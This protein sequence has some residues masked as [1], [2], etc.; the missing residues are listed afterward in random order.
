MCLTP[1]RLRTSSIYRSL[2]GYSKYYVEVPCCQCAECQQQKKNDWY[3]R[4]YF[5]SQS[6][7]K[8][9]DGYIMLISLTY[10][11]DHLPTVSKTLLGTDI[12]HFSDWASELECVVNFMDSNKIDMDIRKVLGIFRKCNFSCF[13][14]HDVQNFLKLLRIRL[15]RAGYKVEGNL[16]YFIAAEYGHD[17]NY[18]DSRGRTRKGTNR[19]HYHLLPY[20]SGDLFR[21]GLTPELLS[22]YIST[23]WIYG[24]TDGI[25]YMDSSYVINHST[26]GPRYINDPKRLRGVQY[27]VTKYVCKDY[28]F[29]DS[30]RKRVSY[31]LTQ[32]YRIDYDSP[33]YKERM[34]ELLRFMSQF[35]RQSL[36]FGYEGLINDI[37]VMDSIIKEGNI[38]LPDSDKVVKTF[39]IPQYYVRKIF[40]KCVKDT[41]GRLHWVWNDQGKDW[42]KDCISRSVDTLATKMQKW[43][44]NIEIYTD[45]LFDYRSKVDKILNGRSFKDYAEYIIYYKGRFCEDPHNPDT[46]DVIISRSLENPL[47]SSDYYERINSEGVYRHGKDVYSSDYFENL[48]IKDDCLGDKY[49]GF[50]D[51]YVLYQVSMVSYNLEKQLLYEEKI[52]RQKRLKA[53]NVKCKVKN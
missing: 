26:F 50:D 19:P 12:D 37:S 34:R 27:Y 6:L 39:S 24:R 16:R 45:D 48:V 10:D 25:P 20:V 41:E 43:Y 9:S 30:I 32:L 36:A 22:L 5:E 33:L 47:E 2:N 13:D 21:Q 7:W 14:Y 46:P 51:L 17:E 28:D 3:I 1:V 29:S 40:Q 4:N 49:K 44:D 35:H 52:N 23:A 11:D 38:K 15:E 8:D 18:V 53:M 31:I 42:R